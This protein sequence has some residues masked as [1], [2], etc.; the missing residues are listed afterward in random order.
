ME[1]E[2]GNFDEYLT[3]IKELSNHFT[4]PKDA[5]NAVTTTYTLLQ[6][7]YNETLEHAHF[8]NTTLHTIAIEIEKKCV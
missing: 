1:F 3:K 6:E 4:L 8:E 2:H 5:C 7:L